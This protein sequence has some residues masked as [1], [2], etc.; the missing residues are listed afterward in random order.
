MSGGLLVIGAHPDDEVLLAGGTLA[1]CAAAGFPTGVICLTRGEQGPISDPSLANRANLG[2][3][4]LLELRAACTELGV[5]FVRC[6]RRQDGNLRW[7]NHSAIVRQ[8][9]AVLQTR[10][11]N[12][13][14]TFGEDGLYYHPDH[15]ATHEL[16]LRA[17]ERL[18]AAPVL[19]RSLWPRTLTRALG[20][21]LRRRG[22]APEL[23]GVEA[24]AFGTDELDGSFAVDVNPYVERK[25]RA[26][27]AHRTQVPESHP[28]ADPDL[29]RR[30]G[31]TEWFAPVSGASIW[32]QEA[33][34]I[35]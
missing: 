28:L 14:I 5:P 19:Y 22:R 16:A 26:L 23:W 20:R 10:R 32:L 4:R 31:G 3:V 17:V 30:F 18:P 1:A 21:E 11:P 27:R 29:M 25:L 8:L 24:E 7:A 6:Y 15:V 35:G 12:A 33:L 13:V 2:D 9:A 34:A